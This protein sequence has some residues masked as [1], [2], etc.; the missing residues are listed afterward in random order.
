MGEDTDPRKGI[1]L[2]GSVCW[3]PGCPGSGTFPHVLSADRHPQRLRLYLSSPGACH[4][5]GRVR[6]RRVNRVRCGF[7]LVL[8]SDVAVPILGE[9]WLVP[10]ARL[11]EERACWVHRPEEGAVHA[12]VLSKHLLVQGLGAAGT[13]QAQIPALRFTPTDGTAFGGRGARGRRD[14]VAAW[15]QL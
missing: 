10:P 7:A 13:R 15:E 1:H 9:R 8:S 5:V 2:C 3:T 14:G 12:A 4:G 11:A 6:R